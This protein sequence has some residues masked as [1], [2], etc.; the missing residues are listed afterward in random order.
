MRSIAPVRAGSF[1]PKSR[2]RDDSGDRGSSI[3]NAGR[4]F[5]RRSFISTVFTAIRYS[6]VE[7]AASPRK[8]PMARKT[9]R[10]AS[11]VRSSASATS[12]V[13][14]RHTE[15]EDLTQ[16]AFLQVF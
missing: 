14:I 1:L 2:R 15:A 6:Q 8:L 12:L 3:E 11:W 9:C 7:N 4:D 13:I 10:N 16:E 5:R